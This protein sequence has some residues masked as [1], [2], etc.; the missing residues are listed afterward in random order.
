MP[1]P[2][3][4][5]VLRTSKPP[6]VARVSTPTAVRARCATKQLKAV[7]I[8]RLVEGRDQDRLLRRCRSDR[9]ARS[10]QSALAA[11][12]LVARAGEEERSAARLVFAARVRRDERRERGLAAG[13]HRCASCT[14]RPSRSPLR[15]S[16]ILPVLADA[17]GQAA[18][19][20]EV[21]DR[22]RELHAF[23][24][25][26]HRA[27]ERHP[28]RRHRR[29]RRLVDRR[30][31]RPASR[32][33]APASRPAPCRR[34]ASHVLTNRPESP[35]R[36]SRPPLAHRGPCRGARGS[37]SIRR[38]PRPRTRPPTARDRARSRGLDGRKR[39]RR[40]RGAD[41]WNAT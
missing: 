19:D 11:R 3:A 6:S 12:D 17:A 22:P 7:L 33:A 13:P 28:R 39:V 18:I 31:R 36:R 24:R 10:T 1:T 30:H 23:E 26:G 16:R 8:E 21:V 5:Q 35:Y 2:Q 14:A 27:R 4:S 32:S 29:H 9:A 40:Q 15:P 25:T 37:T 38:R 34:W 41:A 20:R